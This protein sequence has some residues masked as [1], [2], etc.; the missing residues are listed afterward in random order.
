MPHA[1]SAGRSGGFGAGNPARHALAAQHYDSSLP[2][3]EWVLAIARHKLVD[4]WL[5]LPKAQRQA[6]V[7]SNPNFDR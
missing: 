4:L 5:G 3:G 7:L 6:I 2:V 1:Q